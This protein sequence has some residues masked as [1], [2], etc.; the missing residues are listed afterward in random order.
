M[1]SIAAGAWAQADKGETSVD[2]T[3]DL[4]PVVV[5]G[6]GTHQRLKNTPA[7][8]SVITANEIK[9]AGITDFQQAMTMMVPSLSF[10]PNAMG[11]YLMMNGLSNKYVLILINGRKVTGDI[12]GNIDISQIDMSRVK[13]IEVLNGAASSLYGSDAIAGVINIITNQ[14]K[15]EISFTTNS[16]YTRKNQ[17]SQG[18]NLDIAKGKL[19]SYII[20]AGDGGHQHPTQTL[21]DLM[22]IRELRGS[23][24]NFTIG[25]CGDLKFGRT[26]HSLISSLVRYKNVKFVLISPKE[27]RIP[28]YIRDDVLKANNCDFVEVENLEQ[29]MP[30]LDILYMTRVQRERFFSED[31]YLRMK[32]FYI[33]DEDKMALGKPDMYVLHPLPRVNEIS[34]DVDND[35][36]AA[37]FKQVQFGVYVRM[38]LILTLLGLDT[39]VNPSL[40]HVLDSLDA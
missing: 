40:A 21:T 4:N 2:K 39:V 22:T 23:L 10:S 26:V 37:Y 30:E 33:L 3:V 12:S 13:R 7:P 36:R 15:D 20:N 24:D 27:L 19:A 25:L 38:A 8:V 31:E 32:D 1:G 35:D 17:F 14:P 16:R 29:A 6:T 28:D 18:L 9:R 34:V 5:T 11:S